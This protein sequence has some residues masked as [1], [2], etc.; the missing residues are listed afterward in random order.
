MS[1]TKKG[2]I[3]RRSP[4][5][6]GIFYPE[7]PGALYNTLVSWGLK[8]GRGRGGQVIIAPHGA[9]DFSGNIAGKAF[10]AVQ[11]KSPKTGS[12]LSRVFLLGKCHQPAEEGIYLSDSAA[13]ETPLGDLYV[14][15]VMNRKLAS[16]STLIRINDIPHL[17]EHSLEVLLPPLK[18]C[19]P[20]AAIVPIVMSGTRPLLVSGLSRALRIVLEKYMEES[21]VIISSNVSRSP[22]PALALSM[23]E[24][25]RSLLESMD[26]PSFLA[27]LSA[28]R[29]SASGGALVGALLESGLLDGRRFSALCPMASCTGEN[30]ETVYYGAFGA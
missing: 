13:F 12:C 6:S 25:F 8:E 10:A 2:G 21:L 15:H 30:S 4:V 17:G 23:A 16:C 27:R 20:E 5:V 26:S 28:G 22:D 1:G 24:D 7:S 9:W 14:D 3:R 18:F 19:F 29:I 11:K